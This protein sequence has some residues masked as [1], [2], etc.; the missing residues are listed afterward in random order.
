MNIIYL[1][2]CNRVYLFLVERGGS[3]KHGATRGLIKYSCAKLG[4]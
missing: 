1:I 3:A 2:H 4:M